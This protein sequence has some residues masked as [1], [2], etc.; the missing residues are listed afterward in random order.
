MIKCPWPALEDRTRVW[1]LRRF[2]NDTSKD[3]LREY[4]VKGKDVIN[5]MVDSAHGLPGALRMLIDTFHKIRHDDKRVPTAEDFQAVTR[6]DKLYQR[7][8]EEVYIHH[9]TGTEKVVL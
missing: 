9:I 4:G 3:M 7:I 5:T 8:M 6:D 2:S 1:Q